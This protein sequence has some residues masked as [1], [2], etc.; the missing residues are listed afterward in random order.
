MSKELKRIARLRDIRAYREKAA[1]RALATARH[2]FLD[3]EREAEA[4]EVRFA[5][6]AD[7]ALRS[8]VTSSADLALERAYVHGLARQVTVAAGR[9]HEAKVEVDVRMVAIAEAHREVDRID[10]WSEM[11]RDAIRAEEARIERTRDDEVA[12]RKSRA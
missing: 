3:A 12:A 1:Q 11:A 4:A 7:R 2:A 6:A 10:R 8:D 5:S 9:I